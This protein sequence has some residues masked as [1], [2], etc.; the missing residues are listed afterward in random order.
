MPPGAGAVQRTCTRSL[1]T[2][3]A[4]GVQVYELAGLL[5]A[6]R[7]PAAHSGR[8]AIA[9]ARS[10]TNVDTM[11]VG[12]FTRSCMRAGMVP[13]PRCGRAPALSPCGSAQPVRGDPILLWHEPRP[14][15]VGN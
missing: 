14:L 2:A 1:K 3:T 13:S 12:L 4:E 10:T 9:R 8:L 11:S 5:L 6:A 7:G 15:T